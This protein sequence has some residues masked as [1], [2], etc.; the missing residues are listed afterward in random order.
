MTP[1][2]TPDTTPDTFWLDYC[3]GDDDTADQ[4]AAAETAASA[5]HLTFSVLR[6]DPGTGEPWNVVRVDQSAGPYPFEV[7]VEDTS[8]DSIRAAAGLL[9]LD[10]LDAGLLHPVN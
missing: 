3:D 5:A 7:A 10:M 2:T 1:T 9:A 6:K 4:F 8:P